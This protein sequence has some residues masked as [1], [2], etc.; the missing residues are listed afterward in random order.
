MTDPIVD[1]EGEELD[2][3]PSPIIIDD[4]LQNQEFVQGSS[5]RAG[6]GPVFLG[7]INLC[8]PSPPPYN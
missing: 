3:A 7:H 4:E 5:T 2:S 6:L 1:D 8:T